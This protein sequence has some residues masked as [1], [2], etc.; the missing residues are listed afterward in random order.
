MDMNSDF[1]R[2]YISILPS[3]CEG[4]MLYPESRN[5]EV[6]DTNNSK[7]KLQKYWSWKL[8]EYAIKNTLNRDIAD[9]HFSKNE[10]GKW[11]TNSFKFS[12]THTDNFVGIA[13]SN[14]PIGIDIEKIS[15]TQSKN[16][17]TRTLTLS[18]LN[19]YSVISTEEQNSYLITKWTQKEAIFKCFG[20]DFFIPNTIDTTKFSV[21]SK[22]FKYENDEYILSV[23]TDFSFEIISVNLEETTF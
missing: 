8:L 20:S 22:K 15:A 13:I 2:V 18:E 19:E 23:A 4:N 10:F 17:P 6:Y 1:N 21:Y 7:I 16:F 5:F 12:I 14:N 11:S 3:Q 9:F